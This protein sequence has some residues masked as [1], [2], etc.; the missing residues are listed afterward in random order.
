MHTSRPPVCFAAAASAIVSG[1]MPSAV[2]STISLAR[3]PAAKADTNSMHRG[4]ISFVDRFLFISSSLHW[5]VH[6]KT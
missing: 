1:V 2:T 4:S 5:T 3:F 6:A